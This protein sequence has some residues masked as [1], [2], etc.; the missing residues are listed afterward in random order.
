MEAT[1]YFRKYVVSGTSEERTV[2]T[3]GFYEGIREFFVKVSW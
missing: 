2:M 1:P 3:V